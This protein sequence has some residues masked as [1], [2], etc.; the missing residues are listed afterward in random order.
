MFDINWSLCGV[1]CLFMLLDII[2][3]FV[4]AVV[5]KTVDSQVMKTGIWHKCG[6]IMA[7]VFAC[8]CEISIGYVDMGFA[9]PMV[10]AVC[11][12]LIATEC[13]SILENLAKI[14]PELANAKFMGIFKSNKIE[15][16]TEKVVDTIGQ[17]D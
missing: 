5:N 14:S 13:V 3:G 16:E 15:E 4:K 1:T 10:T 8:L 9:F 11:G 17:T 7:I 12:Y 2:T 6:F